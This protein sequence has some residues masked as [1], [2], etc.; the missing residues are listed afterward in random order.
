MTV[1]RANRELLADPAQTVMTGVAGS[2]LVTGD[3]P[4]IVIS[5]RPLSAALRQA[6]R[7]IAAERPR[8]HEAVNRAVAAR[9]SML[10][11]QD[12]K[13]KAVPGRRLAGVAPSGRLAAKL[14]DD[15]RGSH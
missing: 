7:T 11:Q 9:V 5:T 14:A 10:S 13:P 6:A 1:V 2:K 4:G 8:L 12:E 3:R 15:G